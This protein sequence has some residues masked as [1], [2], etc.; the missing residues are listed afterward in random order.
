MNYQELK[1]V[2]VVLVPQENKMR[3]QGTRVDDLTGEGKPGYLRIIRFG[4]FQ[5]GE[6]SAEIIMNEADALDLCG[7]LNNFF[8]A[9]M[10]ADDKEINSKKS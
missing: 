3:K 1:E 6:S 2:K 10:E 7:K 4:D 5:S 9:K 8:A